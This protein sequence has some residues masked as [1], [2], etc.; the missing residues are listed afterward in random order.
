LVFSLPLSESAPS[1]SESLRGISFEANRRLP[2]TRIER[3]LAVLVAL[4][5]LVPVAAAEPATHGSVS[6][7]LLTKSVDPKEFGI[8]DD[9]ATTIAAVSFLVDSD[10]VGFGP[11]AFFTSA[12]LGRFCSEPNQDVHYYAT[13]NIPAGAIIDF[14]RVNNLT[15]TDSVMGV[16]LWLRYS[17]GSKFLLAGYSF[18]AHP[19]WTTDVAGPLGIQ[20]LTNQ[21]QVLVLDV[22]QAP[23]SSPEFFAF[24][25][26]DWRRVVSPAPGTP[27]FTDVPADNIYYQFI[28]ALA[29]AGIT[30]GCNPG[31]YCPD[32]SITRAEMAVFLSKALGLHWPN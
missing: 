21:D 3:L 22:E 7:P 28:E 19:T 32:R 15:D 20:I 9:T 12:S 10:D 26:V 2:M 1:F 6:F 30:G 11:P 18:P 17:D 23:S 5:S 13:L 25:E 27:T 24:V 31:L 14:I 8:L 4:M 29:A 16:G